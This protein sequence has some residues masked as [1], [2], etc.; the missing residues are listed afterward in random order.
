MSEENKNIFLH[1]FKEYEFLKKNGRSN[2]NGDYLRWEGLFYYIKDYL[3]FYSHSLK[4][5]KCPFCTSGFK[6]E[7][8]FYFYNKN[9]IYDYFE[10]F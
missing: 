7:V 6:K 3:N 2:A 10:D 5:I 4:Y 1:G 9:R 8:D